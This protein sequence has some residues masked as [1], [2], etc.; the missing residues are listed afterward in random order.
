MNKTKTHGIPL[1]LNDFLPSFFCLSN[2]F[3]Y[4]SFVFLKLVKIPE[5]FRKR[6]FLFKAWQLQ[7]IASF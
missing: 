6:P 4:R 3:S 2:T 5:S 7:S 1:D